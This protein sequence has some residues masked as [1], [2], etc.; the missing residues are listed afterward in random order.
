M[1]DL[2]RCSVDWKNFYR[3]KETGK[4]F[5]LFVKSG[6]QHFLPKRFFQNEELANFKNFIR[7][8][9]GEEAYLKRSKEKLGLK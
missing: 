4:Y 8:K 1:A 3:V 7:A 2:S 6:E 5:V 9:F